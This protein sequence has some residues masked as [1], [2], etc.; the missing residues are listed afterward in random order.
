[1][2]A[3][4]PLNR[5]VHRNPL[6]RRSHLTV[7]AR[8]FGN[9]PASPKHGGDDTGFSRSFHHLGEIRSHCWEA[10]EVRIDDPLS[11]LLRDADV[12]SE[13]ERSL[14]VQQGVVDDLRASA[15]LV[16]IES[17]VRTE[18]PTGGLGMDVVAT[19]ECIDER[20]VPGEVRQHPQLDLRV[21][22]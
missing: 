15:Q 18:H 9:Q 21:V 14:P 12:S 10:L 11:R 5:H 13:R 6:G 3:A 4:V 22:G 7:A 20:V 17:A 2:S 19:L 16:R 8:Q 1:M